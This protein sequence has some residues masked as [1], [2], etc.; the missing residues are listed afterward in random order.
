MLLLTFHSF[1]A[2]DRTVPNPLSWYCYCVNEFFIP[3]LYCYSV[4]IPE[5]LLLT[6]HSFHSSDHLIDNGQFMLLLTRLFHHQPIVD[7]LLPICIFAYT[8]QGLFP[9]Y[10]LEHTIGVIIANDVVLLCSNPRL[11]FCVP[12]I[13]NRIFMFQS[14]S[15]IQINCFQSIFNLPTAF[16]RF[17]L[18]LLPIFFRHV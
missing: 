2:Y 14:I 18:I 12:V 1:L 3:R 7:V 8:F 9:T 13:A 6:F 5:M 4:R 15:T 16:G 11:K 17:R 10:W